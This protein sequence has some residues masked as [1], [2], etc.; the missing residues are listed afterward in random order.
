MDQEQFKEWVDRTYHAAYN[1]IYLTGEK[2]LI[3]EAHR[4]AERTVRE[5]FKVMDPTSFVMS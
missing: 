4:V 2:A 3:T 5:A 1:D